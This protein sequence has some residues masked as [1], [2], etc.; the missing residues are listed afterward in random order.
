VIKFDVMFWPLVFSKAPE[1]SKTFGEATRQLTL[2][3]I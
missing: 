2:N 1:G 3:E